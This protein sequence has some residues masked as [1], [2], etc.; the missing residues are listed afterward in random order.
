MH[1][2]LAVD[3]VLCDASASA[4]STLRR[5]NRAVE[6][7]LPLCCDMSFGHAGF[8]FA[9]VGLERLWLKLR[10]ASKSVSLSAFLNHLNEFGNKAL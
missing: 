3:T 1:R 6:L 4:E 2:A 5:A 10:E 9:H 8:R 7:S